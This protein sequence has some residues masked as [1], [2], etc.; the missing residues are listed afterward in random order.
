MRVALCI[1]TP[2]QVFGARLRCVWCMATCSP[3]VLYDNAQGCTVC[4]VHSVPCA[5][6]HVI[7]NM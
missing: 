2:A 1:Y 6:V 5:A 4:A 7:C 3:V